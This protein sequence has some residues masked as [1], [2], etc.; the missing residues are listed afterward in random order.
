M[1]DVVD[2]DTLVEIKTVSDKLSTDEGGL[3]NPKSQINDNLK[4]VS[5]EVTLEVGGQPVQVKK[6][7]YVFSTTKGGQA[8]LELMTELL[9][10]P[11]YEGKVSF[12]VYN[13]KGQKLTIRELADLNKPELAWLKP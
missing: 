4:M 9:S 12:D 5:R 6:L 3:D 8:N 11:A 7:K 1:I 2:G 13:P 10:S